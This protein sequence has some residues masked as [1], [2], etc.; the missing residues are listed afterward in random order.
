MKK[1][2]LPM[3]LLAA[4]LFSVTAQ[5]VDFEEY[6]LDNG[7]HVILQQD[8]TAPLV[9]TSVM[10]HV[11]SKD[12]NPERTGFAHFFEH[13]LFEGTDNIKKGQWF[14]IVTANGGKNNANTT[15]D[16]TYY[17]E[18]F[19]TN[20]LELSL[21]MESERMLHPVINQI[22]VDTQNEV[23]KEEKRLRMDNQPY[24][25]FASALFGNLFSKHPYRWPVI[26]SMEHLDAATLDE[27]LAFN[28]KFYV[29]NNAV[30]VVAGD[31]DKEKTKKMIADY[32]G[33]IPRGKDISRTHYKEDP[34]TQTKRARFEDPNIQV[35]AILTAYRT[36]SMKERDAYVLDMIS[37]VLSDG[38]SSRLYKKLVDTEKKA[39]E[40]GAFNYSL[41][42]YGAYIIYALPLG[43]TSLDDLVAEIDEEIVKLQ[44]E[45]I[46]ERD[47]EKLQNQFENSFVNANSGVEGIAHSLARYYLLYG[48]TK[49]INE[50]IEIYRSI[51]REEIREV[52]KKY[53][54]PD[55]R[56]LLDYV[57]K[58]GGE[59]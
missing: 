34:I 1:R 13:L 16:R 8:N 44:T 10:Y 42:D 49:L 41:E 58:E 33:P 25:Q 21:W 12:E 9:T 37:S 6:D 45:L 56:L 52:A 31:I 40:V 50:E 29:P 59:N 36:P 47:Y 46:S 27:F 15:Q 4:S 43:G 54:K 5:E 3:A 18:V 2:L 11:G 38:K 55:Q 48:N 30:L 20:N 35:P 7:L 57:P 28:K 32:F 39:M 51:T 24:G 22:G 23:V 14:K 26:G 17:Y 19:P 53:L